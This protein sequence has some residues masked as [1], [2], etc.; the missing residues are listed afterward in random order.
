MKEMAIIWPHSSHANYF[1]LKTNFK[2][3]WGEGHDML[4]LHNKAE[5][6]H[7]KLPCGFQK[8]E[9]ELSWDQNDHIQPELFINWINNYHI[10]AFLFLKWEKSYK[11]FCG[12]C[13]MEKCPC[14]KLN[15]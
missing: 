13:W 5:Q 9:T 7:F 14:E 6:K 15:Y 8:N 2:Q 12:F 1:L 3:A 11:I 10:K 4:P